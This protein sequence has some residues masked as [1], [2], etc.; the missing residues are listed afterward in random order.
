MARAFSRCVLSTLLVVTPAFAQN[1]IARG[2]G[3][4][5]ATEASEMQRTWGSLQHGL[6][7]GLAI[8]KPTYRLGEEVPLHIVVENVSAERPTYS[9]PYHLR[10][11]YADHSRMSIGIRVE[12][13]DGPLTPGPDDRIGTEGGP[14]ICPPAFEHGKAVAYE[15]KLSEFRLLP[16]KPG[17]YQVTVV[18]SPFTAD[19]TSCEDVPPYDEKSPRDRPYASVVSNSVELT[20]TGVSAPTREYTAWKK[21]LKLADT[22]FGP[23][24][25]LLDTSTHLEWL[26][27]NFSAHL[28]YKKVVAEMAP[29]GRFEGWRYATGAELET[30]FR[31]FAGP[32]ESKT[33]SLI[34][35]KLQR[36]LGGPLE[37]SSNPTTGWHRSSSLGM[38]ADVSASGTRTEGLHRL[39]QLRRCRRN[40][41]GYFRNLG[42]HE[43]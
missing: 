14:A 25:A 37:T 10:V 31:H 22:S 28:T 32:A 36:L 29:G 20:I 38:V 21:R 7:A 1:P 12:D 39:R 35:A 26:R 18:W 15:K 2:S 30:F 41:D 23:K 9:E 43:G 16:T 34:E 33:D 24:T 17:K 27:L 40:G 42:L 3:A 6:H 11:A 4:M 8:D 13:K 19:A 5:H